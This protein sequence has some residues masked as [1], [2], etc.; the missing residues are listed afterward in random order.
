MPFN[1]PYNPN[2][3][4]N[5][6]VDQMIGKSY[7]VVRK[8]YDNLE[9]IK[10]IA[11]QMD[12]VRN[13]ARNSYRSISTL[14]GS[15]GIAG[16]LST[17]SVPDGIPMDTIFDYSVLIRSEDGSL[18][19]EAGGQFT[20]RIFDGMLEVTLSVSADP[21]LENADIVWTLSYEG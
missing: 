15:T 13:S 2:T 21:A 11:T 12:V 5:G 9:Y 17:I 8:V 6:L 1:N 14:Y 10:T 4:A 3:S 18:Y 20:T 16:E 19:N 7:E